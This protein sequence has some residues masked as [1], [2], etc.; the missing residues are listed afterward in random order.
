MGFSQLELKKKDEKTQKK[1][2]EE[3]L[4]KELNYSIEILKLINPNDTK[5]FSI[6]KKVNIAR[7]KNPDAKLYY[8]SDDNIKFNELSPYSS[9]G[10]TIVYIENKQ[11]KSL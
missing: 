2:L 4:S 3:M 7:K 11:P 8:V 1:K 5:Y 6:E 9:L 10:Y